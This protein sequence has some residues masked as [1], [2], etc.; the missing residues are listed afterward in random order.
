[1]TP[2]SRPPSAN[3]YGDDFYRRVAE[4]YLEIGAYNRRIA[5]VI[6]EECDVSVPAAHRWIM[7]ARKRG[8]LTA[9]WESL[10]NDQ[11]CPTC[12]RRSGAPEETT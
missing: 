6:A 7:T 10:S 3:G 1:M 12:G 9:A 5:P 8:F 11:R 4:R 2:L